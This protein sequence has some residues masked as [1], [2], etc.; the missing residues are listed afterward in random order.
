MDKPSV[1][2]HNLVLTYSLN[3]PTFAKS[4]LKTTYWS[5]SLVGSAL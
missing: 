2:D 1:F 5:H 3:P 4:S